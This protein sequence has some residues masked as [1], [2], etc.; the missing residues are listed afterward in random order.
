MKKWMLL[1]L[2]LSASVLAEPYV[3]EEGT[4]VVE[5]LPSQAGSVDKDLRRRRAALTASPENL[6]LATELARLYIQIGRS[7]SDPRYLG[8]AQAALSPWWDQAAP[9]ASVLIL[10]A[11]LKQ[12][13]H[14]FASALYD[15]DAVL[16]A[17]PRNA[18]ALLTRAT[19]LQVQGKPEQAKESCRKLSG[20]AAELVV[21]T[22][23]AGAASLQGEAERSYALLET[24]L[25]RSGTV[26]PGLKVWAL[27][28]QAEIAERLGRREAA[29]R[30]FRQ[31]LAIDPSDAYLL[32][33]YADLLLEQNRSAEVAA[34]LREH[35]RVDSLLLRY[36][37]A[38]KRQQSPEIQQ[39]VDALQSRF[40]AAAM[41][42]DT[43]HLREQA[44]FKLQLQNDPETALRIA[45]ENWSTQKEP[46]D[47]RLLLEAALANRDEEPAKPVLAWMSQTGVEDKSLQELAA[48]LESAS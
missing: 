4:M 22:C 47:A 3:P 33:A 10:R 12:S 24:T 35:M 11:T 46:A 16:S 29:E 37:L 9:P 13:Q 39:H 7:T 45:Q 40:S 25:Q 20:Q 19:I 21:A 28:L 1:L 30:H 2:L 14:Q 42:G 31:A 38:L 17:D 6:Q 23:Y 15:L 44:R 27:T 26:E 5:R 34:L 41:R 8:Y 48:K 36:T 18:Q 43:V 32:G